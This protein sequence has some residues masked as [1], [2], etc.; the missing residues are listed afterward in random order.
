MDHLGKEEN[1]K[2]QKKGFIYFLRRI[3]NFIPV[4]THIRT[5]SEDYDVEIKISK[6]RMKKIV[7]E[8]CLRAISSL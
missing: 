7:D 5:A 6:R 3:F 2:T 1:V 8:I 4:E